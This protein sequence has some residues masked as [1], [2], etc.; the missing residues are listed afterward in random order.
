MA[1]RIICVDTSCILVGTIQKFKLQTSSMSFSVITQVK[2]LVGSG[3]LD[4][5]INCRVELT[6]LDKIRVKRRKYN[7]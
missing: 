3:E 6:L 2:H 4:K 7:Q 1:K 5:K